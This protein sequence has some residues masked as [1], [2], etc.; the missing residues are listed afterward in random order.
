MKRKTTKSKVDYIDTKKQ[1]EYIESLFNFESI[2]INE[3]SFL[4]LLLEEVKNNF[5]EE[6]E[7]MLMFRA[8][9]VVRIFDA[10]QYLHNSPKRKKILK[11]LLNG[12]LDFLN[13]QQSH[14]KNILWELEVFSKLKPVFNN[15]SLDEPDIVIKFEDGDI[16]IACKK[17]YSDKVTE[18]VL[19]KAVKQIENNSFEFG[20]V[21]INIDCSL[22]EGKILNADTAEEMMDV[23]YKNNTK[24]I[25][26]NER[27]FLKYLN[28]SRIIAVLVSSSTIVDL[29][30]GSPKFNN[31]FQWTIWTIPNLKDGHK[32]KMEVFQK[33]VK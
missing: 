5:S 11:D 29:N 6:N 16:G 31:A 32:D 1:I 21:A 13:Y 18:K 27:Y 25:N 4:Y 7:Q 3:T 9:F 17:I 30:K 8:L 19:S 28:K 20:I 22:P 10:L 12:S 26:N 23:L 15:I 33:L 14:A 2:V 24:F